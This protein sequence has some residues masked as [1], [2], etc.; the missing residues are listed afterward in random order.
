MNL[1]EYLLIHLMEECSELQKVASKILRFGISDKKAFDLLD[2]FEDVYELFIQ[3]RDTRIGRHVVQSF[4]DEFIPRMK[5]KRE[6]KHNL[7]RKSIDEGR[8]VL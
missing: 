6:K 3:I 1:D 7:I 5:R 8:I 4:A 2:E